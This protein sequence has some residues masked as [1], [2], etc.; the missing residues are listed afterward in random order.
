M[1][2]NTPKKSASNGSAKKPRK[3]P[4]FSKHTMNRRAFKKAQLSRKMA[5][6]K[7]P[8]ER[9]IRSTLAVSFDDCSFD[10]AGDIVPTFVGRCDQYLQQIINGPGRHLEA[11]GQKRLYPNHVFKSAEAMRDLV[12]PTWPTARADHI[13]KIIKERDE[14]ALA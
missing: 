11:S 6:Q 10:L 12:G 5:F 3:S 1:V 9:L 14:E 7:A 13:F 8:I 2:K 4:T